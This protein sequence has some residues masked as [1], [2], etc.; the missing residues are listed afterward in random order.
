MPTVLTKDGFRFY[1]YSEE[2]NEPMHIHV[3]YA[4]GRAKYWLSPD[5]VLAISI[6][7]KAKDIKKAKQL[8]QGNL[9]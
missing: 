3:A 4:S 9:D 5:V 7:F 8:I 2:G 6:G 1:F